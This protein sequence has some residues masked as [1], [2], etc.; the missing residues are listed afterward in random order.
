MDLRLVNVRQTQGFL[1]R[2]RPTVPWVVAAS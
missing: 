2:V 1:K